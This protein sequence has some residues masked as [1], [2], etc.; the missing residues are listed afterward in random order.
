M[1]DARTEHIRSLAA[2]IV[3]LIQDADDKGT[4]LSLE[5]IEIISEDGARLA[6]IADE[7]LGEAI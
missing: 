3:K 6:E 2:G 4:P 1:L 5:D 7:A